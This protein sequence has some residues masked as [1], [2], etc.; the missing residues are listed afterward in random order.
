MDTLN[1]YNDDDSDSD[2]ASGS[3]DMNSNSNSR[4]NSGDKDSQNN[5]QQH[6]PTSQ[7]LDHIRQQQQPW[8]EHLQAQQEFHNPHFFESIVEQFQIDS[9]GTHIMTSVQQ[10]LNVKKQT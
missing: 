10:H 9:F 1:D 4:K 6:P 2:V 7:R 3:E 8:V 5:Q